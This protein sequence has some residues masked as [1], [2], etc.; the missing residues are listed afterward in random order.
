MATL[1]MI[2]LFPLWRTEVLVGVIETQ[3][4]SNNQNVS[5]SQRG[6]QVRSEIDS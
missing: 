4:P 1:K 5:L 2:T 3:S 6:Q